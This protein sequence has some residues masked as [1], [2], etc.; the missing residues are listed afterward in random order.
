M[1]IEKLSIRQVKAARALLAWSQHDLANA[2]GVS[3]PTIARLE[4]HDGDLGGRAS[5]ISAI[6]T[7]LET[8]GVEFIEKN[9]G[10]E[11]VRLRK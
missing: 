9:G 8:S 6:R 3:Y 10:G 1:S 5:T 11:G 2:S 4:K 7:A